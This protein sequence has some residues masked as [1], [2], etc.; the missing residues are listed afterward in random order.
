MWIVGLVTFGSVVASAYILL[1]ALTLDPLVFWVLFGLVCAVAP[2]FGAGVGYRLT[3][4][5]RVKSADGSRAIVR[6]WFRNEEYQNRIYP[7]RKPIEGSAVFREETT[8]V[9]PHSFPIN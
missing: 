8:R 4:P 2:L 7:N 3:T 9:D 5:V 6:L 1:A